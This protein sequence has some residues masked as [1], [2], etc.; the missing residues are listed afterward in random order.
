MD[1]AGA[2]D[3]AD[4]L[5]VKVSAV[6]ARELSPDHQARWAALQA[7]DPRLDSPYFRPEFT[8]AVAAVRPATEVGILEDASSIVGFFPFERRRFGLAAPVGGAMSDFQGLIGAADRIAD[9]TMLLRGCGLNAWDFDHQLASQAVFAP[10]AAVK[11]R[12]PYVD[13]SGG[14]AAY[15]AARQQAGSQNVPELR[16]KERKLT[17]AL[18]PVRF[19]ADTADPAVFRQTLAWKSAQYRASRLPDVFATQPWT[20]EL[21]SGIQQ[22]RAHG[23]AGIVSALYAGD[24]LIAGHVG[25]RSARVW[26]YWFPAHDPEIG[27][28]SPGSLLLLRMIEHAP[29]IGMM[30]LD[31]G[32]GEARYKSRFM[33]GEV[34]LIEG[35][36]ERDSA[37]TTYRR[38]VRRVYHWARLTPPARALRRLRHG[39]P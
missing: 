10:F 3:A 23:F 26:H 20:R 22:Q 1:A 25:M 16:R 7:G 13:V 36:L 12:S 38:T 27:A 21:L 35:W 29:E 9:A 24:R 17:K 37:V 28:F 19:E 4:D 34:A 15:V 18:G 30:R 11:S 2:R 5:P 6:R 8:A 39:T 31:L 32:K 14:F 33:N